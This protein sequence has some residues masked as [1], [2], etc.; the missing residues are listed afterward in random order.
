MRFRAA[1]VGVLARLWLFSV[2]A[3]HI[4]TPSFPLYLEAYALALGVQDALTLFSEFIPKAEQQKRPT[5]YKAAGDLAYVAGV[6]EAGARNYALASQAF[7]ELGLKAALC[8][9]LSGES[10]KALTLLEA[11]P[12]FFGTKSMV[13]EKNLL[14][15][16]IAYESKDPRRA[17]SLLLPMVRQRDSDSLT[18]R[19]LYVLW[20]IGMAVE[21]GRGAQEVLPK[22]YS[23]QEVK[24]L[25]V[26]RYPGSIETALV[27]GQ[28]I[29]KPSV[30]LFAGF[31]QEIN[32]TPPEPLENTSLSLPLASLPENDPPAFSRLQVGLFSK[33]ENAVALSAKLL[34]NGFSAST[35]ERP[36]QG[37]NIPRWAVIV[38]TGKDWATTVAQLTAGERTRRSPFSGPTSVTT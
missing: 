20:T 32:A 3:K 27:E 33:R 1:A 36:V 18:R 15:A 31:G 37:E 35:E 11:Q 38:L 29:P 10:L 6:F 34:E 14:K 17:V 30:L 13:E 7:P 23:P 28:A 2:L 12:D 24:A 5:L 25:L 8:H 4:G 26:S 19:A 16:W 21:E 22:G 9:L